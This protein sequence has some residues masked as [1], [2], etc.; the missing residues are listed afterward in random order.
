MNVS[1]FNS[2]A[3][4][5][6]DG[7]PTAQRQARAELKTWARSAFNDEVSGTRFE[8]TK[9]SL[10]D[11]DTVLEITGIAKLNGKRVARFTRFLSA[12]ET[13]AGRGRGLQVHHESL[14]MYRN[15]RGLGLGREWVAR[16]IARYAELG[17]SRVTVDAGSS[18]GGYAWADAGFQWDRDTNGYASWSRGGDV[19]VRMRKYLRLWHLAEKEAARYGTP[20]GFTQDSN[21]QLRRLLSQ[22]EIRDSLP[23]PQTILAVG[24]PK[25]PQSRDI[26]PGKACLMGANWS[27]F[28]TV[29]R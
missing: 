19:W 10:D 2:L 27:G 5:V 28:I 17:V 9:T 16:S 13:F 22:F 23:R 8:V 6:F 26:W 12:P 25:H 15:A 29:K 21:H 11:F 14:F 7:R 20:T 3:E 4:I 24:R 1:E 18:M